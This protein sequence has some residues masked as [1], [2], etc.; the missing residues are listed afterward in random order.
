MQASNVIVDV[1]RRPINRNIERK[2]KKS[3]AKLINK[4]LATP[5]SRS[6]VGIALKFL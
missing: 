1:F 3:L 2:M 5:T 6:I 4:E